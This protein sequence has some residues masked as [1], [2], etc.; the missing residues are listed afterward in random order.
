MKTKFTK[1]LFSLSMM[2]LGSFSAYADLNLSAI[3]STPGCAVGD[4]ICLD[5]TV[6]S[7][8]TEYMDNITFSFPAGFTAIPTWTDGSGSCNSDTPFNTSPTAAPGG[9][10]I[11]TGLAS[12]SNCGIWSNGTYTFCFELTAVDPAGCP[13]DVEITANGDGWNCNGSCTGGGGEYTTE[14]ISAATALP[15]EVTSFTA[16]AEAEENKI[17]WLTA[18]ESNTE[19]HIIQRTTNNSNNWMEI[20]RIRAAGNSNAALRYEMMDVNPMLKSYYRLVTI[21]FDQS[22]T[23]SDVISVERKANSVEVDVYPNP[24]ITTLNVDFTSVIR[25]SVEISVIDLTG[26]VVK[27]YVVEAVE[28]VNHIEIDLFRYIPGVYFVSLETTSET[29]TRRLIKK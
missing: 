27:S 13:A 3:T 11:T 6:A 4:V 29:I 1:L 8:T 25:E 18:T 26:R 24:A 21:D 5:V 14:V 15:V 9:A 16:E 7:T 23:I 20:G 2:L 10:S 28:G 12:D 22:E 17:T 19:Y